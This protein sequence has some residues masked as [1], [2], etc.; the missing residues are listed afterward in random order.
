MYNKWSA[1]AEFCAL[2]G[3]PVRDVPPVVQNRPKESKFSRFRTRTTTRIA[4]KCHSPLSRCHIVCEYNPLPAH[5]LAD[6]ADIQRCMTFSLVGDNKAWICVAECKQRV[7]KLALILPYLYGAQLFLVRPARA[8]ATL[9]VGPM[10]IGNETTGHANLSHVLA[11]CKRVD[12]RF[13]PV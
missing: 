7:G 4:L 6:N 8:D 11:N 13:Y 12:R 1:L 3:L 2:W 9:S 10:H 5:K